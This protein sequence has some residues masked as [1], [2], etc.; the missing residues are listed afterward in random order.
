MAFAPGGGRRR[1]QDAVDHGSHH[2]VRQRRGQ[3]FLVLRGESAWEKVP[4]ALT[5]LGAVVDVVPCYAVG[6]ETDDPTGGAARLVEEG[7]DWIV[8]A[9]GLA[10]EHFHARFGLPK[11]KARFPN[12]R[13]AIASITIKWALDKLGLEPSVVARPDNVESIANEIARF[14]PEKIKKNC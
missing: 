8:F 13:L 5:E 4:E 7:A 9:S 14:E 2:K 10:I 11:L 1:S 6:P 12:I 3:R